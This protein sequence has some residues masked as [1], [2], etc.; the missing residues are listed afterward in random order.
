MTLAVEFLTSLKLAPESDEEEDEKAADDDNDAKQPVASTEAADLPVQSVAHQHEEWMDEL[1]QHIS[2]VRGPDDF[3]DR[4]NPARIKAAEDF[5]NSITLEGSL[6]SS[7]IS[8]H[9]HHRH[10]NHMSSQV[11]RRK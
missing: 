11:H 2:S 5:L 10:R 6:I 7:V 4:P 8:T 1:F 9:F 3:G